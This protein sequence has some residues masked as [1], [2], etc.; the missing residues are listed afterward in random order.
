MVNQQRR[1]FWPF[2]GPAL[3]LYGVVFGVPIVL[4][5]LYSFGS[6]GN[7]GATADRHLRP[8]CRG[9]QGSFLLELGQEHAD[10]RGREHRRDVHSG[11]FYRVVPRPGGPAAAV[12]RVLVFAP[13][14]VSVLVASLAWKFLLNPS[15]GLVN[16]QIA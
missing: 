9:V 1:L 4:S 15:W 14:V 5:V 13:V 7:S 2:V 8:L 10:L 6:V 12:F 11:R 16:H 3:I